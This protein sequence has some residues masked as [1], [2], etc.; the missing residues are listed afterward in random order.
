MSQE[1]RSRATQPAHG[2]RGARPPAMV[3][4][5]GGFIWGMSTKISQLNEDRQH[6]RRKYQMRSNR[7]ALAAAAVGFVRLLAFCIPMMML[8]NA[9][10]ANDP[11]TAGA[12][13]MPGA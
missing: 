10:S 7:S 4:A 9:A 2:Y 5:V 1:E 8:L 13:K 6:E 3:R 12:A 11:P